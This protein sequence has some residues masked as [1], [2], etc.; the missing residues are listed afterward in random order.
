MTGSSETFLYSIVIF[1]AVG[2]YFIV[3]PSRVAVEY[4][5]PPLT[6]VASTQL[7]L[8]G[9]ACT[10]RH[11]TSVGWVAS[12]VIV[13]A[14]PGG[15]A[16]FDSIGMCSTAERV[17]PVPAKPTD[18]MASAR[19][20]AKRQRVWLVRMGATTFSALGMHVKGASSEEK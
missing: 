12:M 7:V 15:S 8:H 3:A 5:T 6:S 10:A 19:A 18:R 13:R 20:T 1:P 9:L 2:A 11:P 4:L 16:T 17:L 14:S